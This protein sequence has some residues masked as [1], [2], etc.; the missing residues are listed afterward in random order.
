[1]KRLLSRLLPAVLICSA[2]GAFAQYANWPEEDVFSSDEERYGHLEYFGFYASAWGSW[3]FT[4]ELAP[5]TNLTWIHV[6]STNDIASSIQH[7]IQ[8]A[9]EARDAGVQATISIE[10]FLF[11]G[12]KGRLR[13]DTEIEDFLVELRAQLEFNDLLD[14]V[15]MI[16]PK[17]EPVRELIKDRDPNFIEQYITGEA[18]DEI[19]EDL[20][21]LNDLIKL[22]FPEKP[23]GVILSGFELHHKFFSIPENYDWVGFD[24]YRNLFKS[25]DGKS[26]VEHYSHLLEHM[27]P[28]QRLIAVPQA[29]AVNEEFD[30]A[31][32]PDVLTSRMR[33]HYEIALNEPRFVAFIPFIW[34][35]DAE[36]ETPGLGLNRFAE[37]YDDGVSNRGTAF[38][39]LVKDIGLQIKLGQQEFPNMAYDETEDSKHRPDSRIR[40]EIMSVSRRGLISAWAINTALP[41]KNLRLQVLVRDMRGKLI[42]KA[43]PGRTFIRDTSLAQTLRI[44]SPGVGL[45][46]YRYQLPGH[47]VDRALWQSLNVEM[48][49]FSDGNP[50]ETGFV[51]YQRLTAKPRIPRP[52]RQLMA[53]KRSVFNIYE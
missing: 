17:D 32:L 34:S 39:D 18:Y 4:Q 43:R 11:T 5:F 12:E 21:H 52:P 40:G 3:N 53:L 35:F 42:H 15:A 16:Y 7:I 44:D 26:F 45:H 14:T 23:I 10:Q 19:Y 41:H 20:L 36:A 49:F 13:S 38:V 22:A 51:D 24:C 6:G 31:D 8:R 47:V 29:W 46:G 48:R 30:Q 2:T 1:M 28:H 25:C 37:L 33:H 27:Q 9:A 50:R